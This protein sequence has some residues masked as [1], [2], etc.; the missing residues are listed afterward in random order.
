MTV[1]DWLSL[2]L[3]FALLVGVTWNLNAG[4][5]SGAVLLLG[6][7]LIACAEFS[8]TLV[9]ILGAVIAVVGSFMLLFDKL[10]TPGSGGIK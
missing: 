4:R 7:A 6:L 3:A 10:R 1:K 8:P 5:Y 9:G 2:G